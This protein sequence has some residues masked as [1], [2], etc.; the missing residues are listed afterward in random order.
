M[1]EFF[2]LLRFEL[3]KAVR[4]RLTWILWS[5][6]VLQTV[7]KASILGFV[8]R[9]A[10]RMG[11][12][13]SASGALDYLA[14]LATTSIDSVIV[15]S[16]VF[17]SLILS[18]EI[19]NG[20]LRL[21]IAS[22]FARWKLL[23]SKIAAIALFVASCLMTIAVL[24][25][26]ITWSGRGLVGVMDSGTELIP[27][28]RVLQAYGQVHLI[29]WLPITAISMLGLAIATWSGV[30]GVAVAVTVVFYFLIMGLDR[31]DERWLRLH[32]MKY[33][34]V[35]SFEHLVLGVDSS[36]WSGSTPL[37][38][39]TLILAPLLLSIAYGTFLWRDHVS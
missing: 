31:L 26:A 18:N 2:R 21:M 22:G 25:L 17:A 28:S 5:L 39:P 36:V 16:L 30:S 9:R 33:A 24:N 27:L 10:G 11:A 8:D 1:N 34:A 38:L 13:P 12:Q 29:T 32:D 19:A 35:S 7:C 37:L 4:L 14:T 15:V 23:T 3:Y 6:L 20:G